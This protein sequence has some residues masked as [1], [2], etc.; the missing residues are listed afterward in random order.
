MKSW[1]YYFSKI[2]LV[3]SVFLSSASCQDTNRRPS[4]YLIPDGYVGWLRIDF[5]IEKE[6]ALPVEEG[7]FLFKFSPSGHIKTSSDIEYGWA[8]DEFYYY[9]ENSRTQ[10]KSTG[11]GGGGMIW[12]GSNGW[13]GSTYEERT[14]TYQHLFVGTEDQFNKYA[15]LKN[16][17]GLPKVGNLNVEGAHLRTG[18]IDPGG[19]SKGI[20]RQNEL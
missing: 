18:Q 15:G 7:Y 19:T 3:G 9:S 5:D 20:D 6:P 17:D 12:G 8:S 16:E 1:T 10:L 14:A 2:V 11:W 13:L 4:R